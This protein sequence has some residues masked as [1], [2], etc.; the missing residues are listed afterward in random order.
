V[1]GA[2]KPKAQRMPVAAA[3]AGALL[4]LVY[5]VVTCVVHFGI[6]TLSRQSGFAGQDWARNDFA[7]Q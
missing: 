1:V 6:P 7:F 4:C 2:E 5:A 3:L